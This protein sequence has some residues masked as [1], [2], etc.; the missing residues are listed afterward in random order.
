MVSTYATKLKD[1]RWQKKRLEIL[2]RDNW[3]CRYCGDTES[4]L[5]VHHIFYLKNKE[6]W[7]YPNHYYLTLCGS[8]H[9]KERGR[10]LYE[11]E[12][13]NDLRRTMSFRDFVLFMSLVNT[14]LATSKD[15]YKL[16]LNFVKD[17]SENYLHWVV[18]KDLY[19]ITDNNPLEDY[20][21]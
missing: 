1:P 12:F 11:F 16:L 8:C 21:N 18:G 20:H 7:D 17:V 19:G 13:I 15:D 9:G 6:I 4:T 3:T 5:H 10:E 14:M 2:E